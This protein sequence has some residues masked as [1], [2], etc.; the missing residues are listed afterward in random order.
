MQLTH[1]TV[2]GLGGCESG[3]ECE[4][5]DLVEDR[6][7]NP[8]VLQL[9]VNQLLVCLRTARDRDVPV[10]GGSLVRVILDHEVSLT[11]HAEQAGTTVNGVTVPSPSW[12]PERR[13]V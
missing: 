6:Q 1:T 13:L 3:R 7:H 2:A 11:R 12:R 4:T 9:H 10:M 8:R 5:T